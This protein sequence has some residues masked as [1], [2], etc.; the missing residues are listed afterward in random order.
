MYTS[1]MKVGWSTLYFIAGL[2]CICHSEA[3]A[4]GTAAFWGNWGNGTNGRGQGQYT[5]TFHVC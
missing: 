2:L 4:E 5:T 1:Q 3:Q